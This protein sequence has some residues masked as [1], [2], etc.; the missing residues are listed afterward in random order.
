LESFAASVIERFKNPFIKHNLISIALNIPISELK[1]GL[2]CGGS[3]GLSGIT[4]NPLL[5]AFSDFLTA[6]AGRGTP[7]CTFVPTVKISTNTELYKLKPHWIDFNAGTLVENST[8]EELLDGFIE[9]IIE[10]ASGKW[11]NNENMGIRE[12]AIF[13]TGVIL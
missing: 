5:G 11:I 2:K 6:Q 4:A 13:K 8:M 1:I 12:I 9:Y 3:D 10:T 7:F